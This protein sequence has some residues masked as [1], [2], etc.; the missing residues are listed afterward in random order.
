MST[1]FSIRVLRFFFD[2][3]SHGVR[4]ALNDHVVVEWNLD[5]YS[6]VA[7]NIC[8]LD[9]IGIHVRVGNG[10]VL[11]IRTTGSLPRVLVATGREARSA[12]GHSEDASDGDG[13]A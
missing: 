6:E 3:G 8:R 2:D 1:L 9:G 11:P 7:I 13:V 10:L 12:D 5:G 4:H